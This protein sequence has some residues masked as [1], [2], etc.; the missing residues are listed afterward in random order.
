M[1]GKKERRK[2][3]G[4]KKKKGEGEKQKFNINT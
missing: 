4:K 1:H 2:K 3:G